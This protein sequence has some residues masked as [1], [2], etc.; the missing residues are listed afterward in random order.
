MASE[1]IEQA[2]LFVS[3]LVQGVNFRYRTH[4]KATALGIVG[5]VRNT[6]GGEVEVWAQGPVEKLEAFLQ[7]CHEGPSQARV[8]GVRII[9]R[10]GVDS[11]SLESFEIRY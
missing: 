3:G 10:M 11:I 2:H 4:R 5:W 7:W 1:K 6:R 8:T 9:S